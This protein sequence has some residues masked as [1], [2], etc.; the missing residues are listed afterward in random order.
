[1]FEVYYIN[2]TCQHTEEA[3]SKV[4]TDHLRMAVTPLAFSRPPF[5]PIGVIPAPRNSRATDHEMPS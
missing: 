2:E 3:V 1:M 4:R 5:I